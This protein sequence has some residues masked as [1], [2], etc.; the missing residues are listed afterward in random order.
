MSTPPPPTASGGDPIQ[1]ALALPGRGRITISTSQGHTSSGDDT[2]TFEGLAAENQELRLAQLKDRRAISR[3]EREVDTLKINLEQV[4]KR[5]EEEAE[6]AEAM[7][8]E[9]ELQIEVLRW[10]TRYPTV[11]QQVSE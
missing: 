4:K 10:Q 2:S 5:A 6:Q 9:R 1:P 7:L 8:S 11:G 3:L